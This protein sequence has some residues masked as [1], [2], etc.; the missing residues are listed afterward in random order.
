MFKPNETAWNIF[1]R[2]FVKVLDVSGD[3]AAVRSEGGDLYVCSIYALESRQAA[4]D[5]I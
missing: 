2:T 3:R 4:Y 5:K 1:R